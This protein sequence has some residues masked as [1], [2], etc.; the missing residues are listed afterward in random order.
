MNRAFGIGAYS[1]GFALFC[2]LGDD[3][4]GGE[5]AGFVFG[6]IALILAL[7]FVLPDFDV[8]VA[9]DCRA[10]V[11]RLAVCRADLNELRLGRNGLLDVCF[12]LGRVAFRIAA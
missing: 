7:R 5:L 1:L 4:L 6:Q 9:R 8:L 11:F 10:A 3:G 12:D 2:A